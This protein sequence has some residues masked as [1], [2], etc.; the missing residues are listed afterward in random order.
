MKKIALLIFTFIFVQNANAQTC[1]APSF[2]SQQQ[3]DDFK[4]QNP[5]CKTISGNVN[6][7]GSDIT[8][9]NGLF[10][11]SSIKGNFTISK[12][13]VLTNL[14]GLESLVSVGGR[15]DI[16]DNPAL[17]DVSGLESLTTLTDGINV[18][19]NSSLTNFSA[20]KSLSYVGPYLR[21]VYNKS[22]TSIEGFN[23]ITSVSDFLSI[24]GNDS[25]E[26]LAGLENITWAREVSISLNNKL[27]SLNGLRSLTKTTGYFYISD[28]PLLTDLQGLNRLKS[29]SNYFNIT[30][31]DALTSLSG[32]D[33]LTKA[34]I[35]IIGSSKNLS[36][37]SVKAIC[38]LISNNSDPVSIFSNASG[39]NSVEEVSYFCSSA[40][41][42][43]R[44]NAGGSDFNA[45]GARQFSADKYF[46]GIDRVSAVATGDILNTTDDELY[47]SAR[48]SPFFSYNIP[49]PNGKANVILHFA[50][51]WFGVPGKGPA[52]AGQRQFHVNIEGSRKLANFDIYAAA[53]GALRAIQKSIPVTI[54][55]GM[56]NIDFMTGA[57]DLPRISAIEVVL[58]SL[59]LKPGADAYV[60]DGSYNT[61]NFGAD[62][63]LDV[64]NNAGDPLSNRS[65]YLKF[66]LPTVTGISSAKL[67]VYGHNHE[68]TKGISVHAYGVDDDSWTE[69]GIVKSNAPAASTLSLGYV[70]VNDV[71]KY[72]EVDVSSYV[73]AQQQSGNTQVSLLL[74]DPNKRNTRVI[75][76][77][78]QNGAFPPQLIIQTPPVVTNNTR[79]NMQ[80]IAAEPEVQPV[81]EST[82]Y[83]NPARD[84]FTVSLSM[85]HAGLIA[86]ELINESGKR[87]AIP[88]AEN[89]KPGEKTEVNISGF[90]LNTGIYILKIKSDATT[91]I[92]KVLVAE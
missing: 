66:Q 57:A 9:L 71:Y 51:T 39:C 30:S 33:S 46:A 78:M 69:Y 81:E 14:I 31:N 91:E 16:S 72:Y 11:I 68:N 60:R 25:L 40:T 67:R 44:I 15:L 13:P 5:N 3:I 74:A 28:N 45:S 59:T 12:N 56:L 89:A 1:T 76:N 32:L 92:V 73:T 42:P 38:S 18:T 10:G 83:P 82:V 63:T 35:L 6:I 20:L 54:T 37:C 48:C 27:R 65:S 22:L 52:G 49:M 23:K 70:V 79:L 36:S 29:V 24:G 2:K 47:R 86:L 41:A 84:Q 62:A 17:Q 55:D 19:S 34:D 80:E 7:N 77:S 75:F 53:G 88:A 90:S 85:Q 43:I 50:E 61:T 8:N 58:T 4:I 87:Y 26:S 64:K 21:V